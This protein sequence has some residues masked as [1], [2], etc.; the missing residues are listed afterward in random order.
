VRILCSTFAP[1]SLLNFADFTLLI[2]VEGVELDPIYNKMSV[3]LYIILF[4]FNP[5]KLPGV[6]N[7]FSVA[8]IA[9]SASLK[10]RSFS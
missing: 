1:S 3:T 4:Y 5:E 6:A 7:T 10:L 9:S 2:G 8:A